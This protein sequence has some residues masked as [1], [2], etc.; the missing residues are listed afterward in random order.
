MKLTSRQLK[1]I[2]AEELN[3]SMTEAGVL[4]PA[5]P[6]AGPIGP[7]GKPIIS[8]KTW[9][10]C[11]SLEESILNDFGLAG[12]QCDTPSA[13]DDV[14]VMELGEAVRR[15]AEKLKKLYVA[16]EAR[17]ARRGMR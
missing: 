15:V 1:K 3:K 6:E 9:K 2:I 12:Y 17:E 8:M 13:A 4:V 14:P 7:K 5:D 11:T 16:A 10:I